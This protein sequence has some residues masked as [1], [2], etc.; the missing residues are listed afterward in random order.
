MVEVTQFA[1]TGAEKAEGDC[2]ITAYAFLE[3]V[4]KQEVLTSSLQ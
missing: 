3:G 2:P 1:Q 4:S